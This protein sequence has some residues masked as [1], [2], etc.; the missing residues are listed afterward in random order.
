MAAMR[1]SYTGWR[2]DPVPARNAGQV[3]QIFGPD[4]DG[5]NTVDFVSA[6]ATD[7]AGNVYVAGYEPGGRIFKITPQGTITMVVSLGGGF[8]PVALATDT[9][10]NVFVGDITGNQVH[11]LAPNGALSTILDPLIDGVFL[12]APWN[13]ATDGFGNVF[14]IGEG[15]NT[16]YRI[17]LAE[18]TPSG[19]ASAK[20]IPAEHLLASLDPTDGTIDIQFTPAC[21]ATDHTVYYGPLA[22]VSTY[23]YTGALCNVGNDGTTTLDSGPESVFFLVVAN[24]G[25]VEGS[26]GADSAGAQRPEDFATAVCDVPQDL[27]GSCDTP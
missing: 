14:V 18:S 3:S 5:T 13:I 22:D 21:G 26:Y 15:N 1:A 7:L 16:R 24:N 4:G 27:S 9:A 8:F 25:E 20:S 23:G 10:G 19:E 12:D 17:A 6:L 11:R 2:R